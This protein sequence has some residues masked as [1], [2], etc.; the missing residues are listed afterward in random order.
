MRVTFYSGLAMMALFA[1]QTVA[2]KLEEPAFFSQIDQATTAAP[3]TTA[4][5]AAAAT[6]APTAAPTTTPATTPA[7]P[8]TPAPTKSQT[9][10]EK[11][12]QKLNKIGD[13]GSVEDMMANL[14]KPKKEKEETK[15]LP[16]I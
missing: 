6:P 10:A 14:K 1:T 2:V 7:T 4:T 11:D 13:S 12:Q 8:A 3:A 9:K 5:P 15:D 16:T